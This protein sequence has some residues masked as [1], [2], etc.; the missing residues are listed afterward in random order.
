L[1]NIVAF[2]LEDLFPSFN[3]IAFFALWAL[4]C[5]L[6]YLFVNYFIFY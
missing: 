5:Y 1:L 4:L 2:F 3:Q 6:T